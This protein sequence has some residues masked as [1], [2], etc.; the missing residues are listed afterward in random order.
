MRG[1]KKQRQSQFTKETV[2]REAITVLNTIKHLTV[3]Q[4]KR[5]L[6]HALKVNEV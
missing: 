1:I 2:R 6:L 5:V 4:R 3:D